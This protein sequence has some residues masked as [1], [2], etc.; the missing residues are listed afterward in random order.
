MN[1]EIATNKNNATAKIAEVKMNVIFYYDTHFD[2]MVNILCWI[3]IC[4]ILIAEVKMINVISIWGLA[5]LGNEC[6]FLYLIS[7]IMIL[8][9]YGQYSSPSGWFF[10]L[11]IGLIKSS[12]F[13][14]NLFNWISLSIVAFLAGHCL[15]FWVSYLYINFSFNYFLYF[16]IYTYTLDYLLV[17]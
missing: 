14:I 8:W 7:L 10:F 9:F 5:P 6:D 4:F 13:L 11:N 16:E 3:W 15:V 17:L 12:R 2:S 1:L